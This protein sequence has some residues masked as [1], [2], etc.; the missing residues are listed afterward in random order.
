M[1]TCRQIRL[2]ERPVGAPTAGTFELVEAPMPEPG[3]GEVLCRTLWL[4]LDPYMR[5]RIS[6][7]KSYARGVEPGE[8]MVGECVAEV[9]ESHD[10]AYRPG[11]IVAG[12]GGWQSHWALPGS[13]FRRVDPK[14]S[15][16]STALGVLGMP[17]LTAWVGLMELAEPKPGETVVMGAATGAVGAVAGQLAK[18]E[19]CRVVGVAG[20]AGKCAYATQQLGFDACLDR[21]PPDLDGRLQA[22]CPDGIDIY[23]ELVG[24]AV[25]AA[26]LPL[27][28]L[29]ARMPVIG[30]IAHYNASEP[31]PGP[32]RMPLLIRQILVKRLKLQGM[33]VTDH[34][35]SRPAFEARVGALLRTGQLHY[36]EDVVEGLENAPAAFIGLLEGSNFGKL[37]VKVAG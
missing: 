36:R 23:I 4:S 29:H 11:E 12:G 32:D 34:E 8:V 6:G 31:P 1:T 18:L 13:S 37:L 14:L 17:G 2:V 21:H 35:A 5:G 20:G 30:G 24:G 33:I 7:A 3:A 15:P 25:T 22:A 26:A 10:P 27:L 19:G 28:N 9:V 16:V